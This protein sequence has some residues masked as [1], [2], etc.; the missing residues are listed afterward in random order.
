M[1]LLLELAAHFLTDLGVWVGGKALDRRLSARRVDAFRRGE[2]VR[3]RCRYRLGAQAPAMR[4]GTL[5]LTRSGAVLRTGAESAGARLAGPVSA[6]S[7]GGRGGTSLS[8]TAVPAGGGV[9]PAEVLLTT[10]D[11]ELVRL[12]AGTV[13]GRR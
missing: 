9:V 3:L 13:A 6:V 10:W 2:A 12:V 7:G 11:V 8:C 1:L 5:T 4:R